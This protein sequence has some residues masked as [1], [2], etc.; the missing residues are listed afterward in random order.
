M[1]LA[2]LAFPLPDEITPMTDERVGVIVFTE[3]GFHGGT[4]NSTDNNSGDVWIVDETLKEAGC[5]TMISQFLLYYD[6]GDN[7]LTRF[8]SGHEP[9][10]ISFII[11]A[12]MASEVGA[13]F[14]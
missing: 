5:D 4:S 9:E 7:Y 10:T 1:A 13:R 12:H 6:N 2:I 3:S 14:Q 11:E 8:S